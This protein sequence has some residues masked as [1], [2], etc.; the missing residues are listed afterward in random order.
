MSNILVV[1]DN[2]N[3]MRLFKQILLDIDQELTIIEASSGKEAIHKSK[4]YKFDIVLM[5][6]SLPDM[7]GI[8]TRR[9]LKKN[10][11]FK[12]TT[13]IAV[14][15]HV[16]RNDQEKLLIGFD[17]YLPKPIDEVKMVNLI[18][19]LLNLHMN[20]PQHYILNN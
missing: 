8:Q 3:N 5:D 18:N 11:D 16:S 12:N 20:V 4:D 13:F 19:E 10:P 15:A 17:Y 7:D 6:I 2:K 14:S 9:E 1:E